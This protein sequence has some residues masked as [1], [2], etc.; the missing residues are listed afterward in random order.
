MQVELEQVFPEEAVQQ[1]VLRRLRYFYDLLE[2]VEEDRELSVR[3]VAAGLELDYGSALWYLTKELDRTGCVCNFPRLGIFDRFLYLAS[4]GKTETVCECALP[5]RFK[6]GLAY[7]VEGEEV[8]MQ[9]EV[10]FKAVCE[11]PLLQIE[12]IKYMHFEAFSSIVEEATGVD[13]AGQFEQLANAEAHC[14]PEDS[15]AV[16]NLWRTTFE[17][18]QDYLETWSEESEDDYSEDEVCEGGEPG[19]AHAGEEQGGEQQVQRGVQGAGPVHG[20]PEEAAVAPAHALHGEADPDGQRQRG[21][22]VPPGR[23]PGEER[24]QHD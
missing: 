15:S 24:S 18:V 9:S 13:Q 11:M 7:R 5:W 17:R 22:D 19:E 6:P 1:Q 23:L 21:H 14:T 2:T 20:R 3:E 8:L 12:F 16:D 10:I 4:A